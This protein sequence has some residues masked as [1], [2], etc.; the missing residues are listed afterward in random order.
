MQL[1]LIAS[2]LLAAVHGSSKPNFVFFLQDD[3]DVMLGGF[4]DLP[5]PVH[6]PQMK[7]RGSK[8]THW[9]AHTP[10]CCPSRAQILTGKMFHNLARTP[11]DR[12]DTDGRGHPLQ[13]L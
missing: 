7:E 9:Y 10:V 13:V 2:C 5:L 11:P 6:V 8:V 12:W 4:S 1:M 3:Q